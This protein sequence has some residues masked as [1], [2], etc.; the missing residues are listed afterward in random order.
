MNT[1]A[2]RHL[3]VIINDVVSRKNYPNELVGDER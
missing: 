2:Q 3:T 1:H